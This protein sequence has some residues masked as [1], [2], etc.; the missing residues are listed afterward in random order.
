MSGHRPASGFADFPDYARLRERLEQ[1]RKLGVEVPFGRLSEG[2]AHSSISIGGREYLNFSNYDYLDLCAHPAVVQAAKDAIDRYGTSVSASRLVSGERSIHRELEREIAD[3]LGAQDC[4]VFVSGYLTNLTTVGHLYGPRDLVAH[5]AFV[6][7]SVVHG[8]IHARARRLIFPHNDWEAL[9]RMLAETRSRNGRTLIILEGLYSM[10][11]DFPDLPRFLE[12]KRRHN[13]DLMIDEA[14]SLGVMGERGH[15]IREHFGLAG[16][17]VDIW[18]GTLSKTLASC[19][20]YIA[21]SRELIEYLRLS[22]PGFV[23]SVGIPPA[24]AAAALASLRILR[25]EP[26]RVETL[27]ARGRLFLEC[28]R[29]RGLNTGLSQ[30]FNIVP[31]ITGSSLAAVKLSNALFDEGISVYPIVAPAVEERT[32][33]LRFFLSCAHTEEQIRQTVDAAAH[34][35]QLLS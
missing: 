12:V 35:S 8:C 13:A 2:V 29:A 16:E 25:A 10:D 5:D 3:L 19:G 7:N 34:L 15:G 32:A 20:G 6:H 33:R 22:A 23:Y 14:H 30:G 26:W 21:G 24:S 4:L 27:R 28:A 9:D 17:D 31:L 11:G 1:V 18:M